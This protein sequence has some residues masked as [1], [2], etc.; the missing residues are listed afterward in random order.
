MAGTVAQHEEGTCEGR[1]ARGG[2]M[3]RRDKDEEVMEEDEDE[4][5]GEE[6]EGD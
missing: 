6:E 5:E 4:E 3:R 2:R 1:G